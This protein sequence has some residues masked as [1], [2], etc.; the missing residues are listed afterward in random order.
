VTV[1]LDDPDYF[2]L[3]LAGLLVW[4]TIQ[5]HGGAA[6][7]T[8]PQFVANFTMVQTDPT[9]EWILPS[10]PLNNSWP[11]TGLGIKFNQNISIANDALGTLLYGKGADNVHTS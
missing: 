1:W 5:C 11:V 10:L 9:G 3:T 7:V 2:M 4:L 8:V 6:R